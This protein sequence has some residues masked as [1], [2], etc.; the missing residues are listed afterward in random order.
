MLFA[1]REFTKREVLLRGVNAAAL[2][3]LASLFTFGATDRPT[4]LGV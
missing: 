1:C 4:N 2:L 3:P